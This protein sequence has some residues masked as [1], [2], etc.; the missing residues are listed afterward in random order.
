MNLLDFGMNSQILAFWTWAVDNHAIFY[1]FLEFKGVI[2]YKAIMKT[3]CLTP[4][5]DLWGQKIWWGTSCS[6]NQTCGVLRK[7][8]QES[9]CVHDPSGQASKAVGSKSCSPNSRCQAQRSPVPSTPFSNASKDSPASLILEEALGQLENV[10][11]WSHADRMI[12]HT[13]SMTPVPILWG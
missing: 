5:Q 12:D 2:P 3:K 10:S 13:W 1:S 11:T 8:L 6:E 4:Y 7:W 9:Q